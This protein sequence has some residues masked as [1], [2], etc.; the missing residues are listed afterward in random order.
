M[1]R[2]ITAVETERPYVRLTERSVCSSLITGFY[3][4]GCMQGRIR[5]T[6]A[7]DNSCICIRTLK[8]RRL[9]ATRARNILQLGRKV[10][11]S[12]SKITLRN[13]DLFFTAWH[14]TNILVLTTTKPSTNVSPNRYQEYWIH[15]SVAMSSYRRNL[16]STHW[17]TQD[18]LHLGLVCGIVWVDFYGHK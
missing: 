15:L 14:W 10:N 3:I 12:E 6:S 1:L 17:K 5:E 9:T 7:I 2:W 8:N 4:R 18:T 16:Q 11:V 13:F